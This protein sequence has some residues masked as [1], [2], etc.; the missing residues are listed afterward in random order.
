MYSVYH[1]I[2]EDTLKGCVFY[3]YHPTSSVAPLTT[4]SGLSR[5]NLTGVARQ[6][7]DKVA[8]FVNAVAKWDAASAEGANLI[9][10]IAN[11]KL[12]AVFN[13]DVSRKT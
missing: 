9:V 2:F 5:P 7:K 8:D 10:N 3:I 12:D 1:L 11:V 6:R 13:A 4:L